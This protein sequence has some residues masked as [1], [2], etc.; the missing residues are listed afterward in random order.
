MTR[1][2]VGTALLLL[3]GCGGGGETN[4]EA[5]AAPPAKAPQVEGDV[6]KAER[7]VREQLGNPQG[8]TFTSPRR[9]ISEGVTIICGNYTQGGTAQRYIVVGGEEVFVEPRMQAG[10]MDRAFTEFCGAGSAGSP[11][12]N[13]Q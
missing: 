11:E 2:G 9:S 4:N 8:L 10:Q 1:I 5:A 7:L 13:A 12:E 3:A 6:G